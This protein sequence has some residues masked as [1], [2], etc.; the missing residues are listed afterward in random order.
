MLRYLFEDIWFSLK[1][2]LTIN[3]N[4]S[5]RIRNE[6]VM[7]K[8]RKLVETKKQGTTCT[9]TP[10]TCTGTCVRI[11]PRMWAFLHFFHIFLPNSTL[12]LSY[13]SKPH[14][15][16]LIISILLNSSLLPIF[17]QNFSMNLS[18]NHSNMGYDPY[19]NQI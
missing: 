4:H 11:L 14:Q 19:S 12:Y 17:L 2:I 8:I 1:S 7:A 15:I 18:Q 5:N 3:L 6:H 16:H 10:L 13:T 9:G